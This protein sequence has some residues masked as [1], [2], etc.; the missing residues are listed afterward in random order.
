MIIFDFKWWISWMNSLLLALPLMYAVY[1]QTRDVISF[2]T[3]L[4][5]CAS[6]FQIMIKMVICKFM[7]QRMQFILDDMERFVRD[8]EPLEKEIFL[9]Y[10]KRCG[11]L[12]ISYLI[13]TLSS[14]IAMI[15]TPMV[16]RIPF[17]TG[18]KYPFS[19]HTHPLFDIIYIQQSAAAL[20]IVSMIAID[21]QIATM[22][23]YIISRLKMLEEATRAIFNA[24]EFHL[25]IRQHQHLLWMA[26]EVTSIARYILLTT[27]TMATIALITCG[28]YI[29]GNQ[30]IAM[31]IRI[32][33]VITS[34]CVLVFVNAWPSEMMMRSCEDIGTAIYESAWI[35]SDFNKNIVLVVQRCR[36]P[37]VISVAGLLP[38]LSMNY[39]TKFLSKT[40]SFFT[41]LRIILAKIEA[42]NAPILDTK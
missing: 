18:A 29:V 4:G 37:P 14:I 6:C 25:C 23:W 32:G 34:Y 26:S 19:V 10:I 7:R 30:P 15:I 28:I 16:S 39:Y 1:H 24:K 12:H 11:I 41:T 21:C 31:K 38:I 33:I 40:F 13:F 17:P 9:H 3:A 42:H 36:N 2:V 8:A 35:E 5:T 20:Q 27:V 22:L